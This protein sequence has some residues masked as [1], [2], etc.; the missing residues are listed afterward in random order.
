MLF[1]RK[2]AAA[3]AERVANVPT[4]VGGYDLIF[5]FNK[6]TV[7]AHHV[8]LGFLTFR[9]LMGSSLGRGDLGLGRG[10][11]EPRTGMQ[12]SARLRLLLPPTPSH[13]CIPSP[14][15][16]TKLAANIAGNEATAVAEIRAE[17]QRATAAHGGGKDGGGEAGGEAEAVESINSSR[18]G[19]CAAELRTHLRN[20]SHGG[21]SGFKAG[22]GAHVRQG[23]GSREQGA[24]SL[25]SSRERSR[26]RSRELAAARGSR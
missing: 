2:E 15:T 12:S 19:G 5:P 17:L 6:V 3:A 8:R 18:G 26:D 13:P 21:V 10:D 14:A 9:A 4:S 20:G 16:Q 22:L 25:G 24:G 1:A 7:S 23:A 11:P